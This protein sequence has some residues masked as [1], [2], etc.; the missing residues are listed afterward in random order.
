[1]PLSYV[2]HTGAGIVTITGDYSDPAEWRRLLEELSSDREYRPGFGFIR[3]LR[4]SLAPVGAESVIQTIA[5][6]R[7][8]WPRLRPGRAA[9][10]VKPGSIE[11]PPLMAFALA[12]DEGIPLQLFTSYQEAAA[13]VRA[14]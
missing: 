2:V 9:L 3:D 6:I 14:G 1:M 8:F 13:W 7:E 11:P 4:K 10:L 5:V 12:Q